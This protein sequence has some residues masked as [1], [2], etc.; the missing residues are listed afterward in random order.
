MSAFFNFTSL[1]RLLIL[2]ICTVTYL[3]RQFPSFFKQ[4]QDGG[5]ASIFYKANIIGTRLSPYIGAMCIFFGLQM[6]IA[7]FY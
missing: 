5:V 7:I 2:C 6:L 3:K 1:V 4:K